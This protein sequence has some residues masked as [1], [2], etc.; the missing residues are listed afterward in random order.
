MERR[1]AQRGVQYVVLETATSNEAAVA[2]WTRHGYRSVGVLRRY[3]LNRID[4]Y[5]MQKVLAGDNGCTHSGP[6]DE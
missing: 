3:Y 1:L 4:A 2:F 5:V 6:T